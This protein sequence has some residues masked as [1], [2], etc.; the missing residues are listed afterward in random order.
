[1]RQEKR[2]KGEERKRKV[3]VKTAVSLL[4]SKTTSKFCFLCMPS[5]GCKLYDLETALWWV[6]ALHSTTGPEN[7]STSFKTRFSVKSPGANGL[8]H[9]KMASSISGQDEMNPAFLLATQG[10]KMD[11]GWP[12]SSSQE[13]VNLCFWPYNKSCINHACLVKMAGYWPHLWSTIAH[14]YW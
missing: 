8:I 13:N 3:K 12:A 9:L 14:M 6:V 11:L 5:E 4:N 7:R 1:M 10:G 2:K